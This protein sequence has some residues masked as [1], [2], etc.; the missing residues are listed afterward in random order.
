MTREICASCDRVIEPHERSAQ[1]MTG[2]VE[3]RRQGGGNAIRAAR[4]HG[5]F[6][7]G[8]CLDEIVRG[9]RPQPDADEQWRQL[10]LLEDS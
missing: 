7:H 8:L 2:W 5:A 6:V 10:S 3:K 9:H 4:P 1:L